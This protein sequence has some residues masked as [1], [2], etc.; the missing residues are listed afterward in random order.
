MRA[1]ESQLSG[2]AAGLG[3]GVCME[4]NYNDID[5]NVDKINREI[6]SG[7]PKSDA[8][9]SSIAMDHGARHRGEGELL[10]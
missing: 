6:Q 2:L 4:E 5:H 1:S 9:G 3:D 10:K 7:G 8:G